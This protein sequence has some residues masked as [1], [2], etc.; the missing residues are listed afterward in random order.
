MNIMLLRSFI[1]M[2]QSYG[3]FHMAIAQ[4]PQLNYP[5]CCL[6]VFSKF[7]PFAFVWLWY[8]MLLHTFL[9]VHPGAHKRRSQRRAWE[10]TGGT[11]ECLADRHRSCTSRDPDP[12]PHTIPNTCCQGVHLVSVMLSPVLSLCISLIIKERKHFPAFLCEVPIEDFWPDF[13]W[14]VHGFLV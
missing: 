13:Y 9:Y 4:I 14:V 5:I 1:Q 3:L 6:W 7:S 10:G 11:A 8:A 12:F 2:A